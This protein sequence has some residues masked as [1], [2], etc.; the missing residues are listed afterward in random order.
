MAETKV[1]PTWGQVRQ[2]GSSRSQYVDYRLG[3][4]PLR[5]G[6]LPDVRFSIHVEGVHDARRWSA[7]VGH[8]RSRF[9]PIWIRTGA[10]CGSRSARGWEPRARAGTSAAE[11]DP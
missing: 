10:V 5:K 4:T 2:P 3:A 1:S 9:N 8:R 7:L 11:F 6:M